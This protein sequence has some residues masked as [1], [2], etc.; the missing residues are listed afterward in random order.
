MSEHRKYT[1]PTTKANFPF[2]WGEGGRGQGGRNHFGRNEADKTIENNISRDVKT[3]E[4]YIGFR[5]GVYNKLLREYL[6]LI[7]SHT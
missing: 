5:R 3:G 2:R 1:Q 4:G 6:S 7:S